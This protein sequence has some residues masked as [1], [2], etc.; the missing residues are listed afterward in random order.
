MLGGDQEK[1]MLSPTSSGISLCSCKIIDREV[2]YAMHVVRSFQ[3]VEK[4]RFNL[5]K[6][7]L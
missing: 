2:F 4:Q 1:C 3:A 5:S 6:R 7:F